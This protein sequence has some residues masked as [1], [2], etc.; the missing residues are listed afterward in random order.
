MPNNKKPSV[1]LK[2]IVF[3]INSLFPYLKFRRVNQLLE[4][5][6]E[7]YI[8]YNLKNKPNDA[9]FPKESIWFKKQQRWNLILSILVPA[10]YIG[11]FFV[12]KKIVTSNPVIVKAFEVSVKQLK[13]F[14][15]V[16]AKNKI[17][18]ANQLDINF[19]SDLKMAFY[20]FGGSLLFALLLGTYVT[21][22]NVL[23]KK[24]DEFKDVVLN[25]GFLKKEDQ[26][27]I[28][29]TPLG[30]LFK[31]SPGGSAREMVSQDRLWSAMNIQVG[32]FLENAQSRQ[33]VFFKKT[34]NLK[35]GGEYGYDRF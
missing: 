6:Y 11:G 3:L 26:P 13:M 34:Y 9:N 29:Y 2:V 28:L 33:L 7:T 5:S 30:I 32:E 22:S 1:I 10:I 25:L 27:V 35:E 21:K 12:S 17:L 24:T 20:I 31:L 15:I 23:F 8:P 18:L 16:E 19:S 4:T 14:K